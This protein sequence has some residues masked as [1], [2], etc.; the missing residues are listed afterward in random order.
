MAV[1]FALSVN[2][3]KS[4]ERLGTDYFSLKAD[5]VA[6]TAVLLCVLSAGSK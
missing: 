3:F 6:P 1:K 2:R 4:K 5:K